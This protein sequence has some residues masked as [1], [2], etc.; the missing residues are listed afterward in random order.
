M[1]T[2]SQLST[3]VVNVGL[4]ARIDRPSGVV[5]FASPKGPEAILNTWS[6]SIGKLLEVLDRSCQQIQKESMVHKIAISAR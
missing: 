2:E 6:R 4:A 5:R 1:Q 3:M